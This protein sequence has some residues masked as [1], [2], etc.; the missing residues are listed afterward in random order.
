M[1]YVGLDL[2]DSLPTAVKTVIHGCVEPLF[3][4]V[5]YMLATTILELAG[6][7][8]RRQLQ[9]PIAHILLAA[10]AGFSPGPRSPSTPSIPDAGLSA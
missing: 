5:H 2:P 7:G 9:V 1:A 4:D 3:Q 8:P 10:V 6:D